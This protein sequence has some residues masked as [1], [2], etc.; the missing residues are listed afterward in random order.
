M[1]CPLNLESSKVKSDA[2]LPAHVG[3]IGILAARAGS[4]GR[5]LCSRWTKGYWREN[6]QKAPLMDVLP[7][8]KTFL[9]LDFL[10][11]TYTHETMGAWVGMTGLVGWRWISNCMDG[12][13]TSANRDENKDGW[14]PWWGLVWTNLQHT[15][16]GGINRILSRSKLWEQC[17]IMQP[18]QTLS[19]RR[20][21]SDLPVFFQDRTQNNKEQ[22]HEGTFCYTKL[23]SSSKFLKG[24]RNFVEKQLSSFMFNPQHTQKRTAAVST[25]SCI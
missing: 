18:S 8:F 11:Y 21:P 17:N 10:I 19:T 22:Q 9:V 12:G 6:K 3:M 1:P 4:T 23:S 16:L 2:T 25:L 15:R 20:P 5:N 14:K 24:P 7:S 13:R